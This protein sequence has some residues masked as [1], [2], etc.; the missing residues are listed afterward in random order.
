MG[1]CSAIKGQITL[2]GEMTFY[3]QHGDWLYRI[4]SVFAS[5]LI[6]YSLFRLIRKK[7]RRG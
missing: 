7:I 3:V 2:G 1:Y 5:L 4:A 6:L